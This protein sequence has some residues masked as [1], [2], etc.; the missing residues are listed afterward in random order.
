MRIFETEAIGHSVTSP[1]CLAQDLFKI[2][3]V[4]DKWVTGARGHGWHLNIILNLR[5]EVPASCLAR[6]M[7]ANSHALI[8]DRRRAAPDASRG[9]SCALALT[10]EIR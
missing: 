6:P 8:T 7:N 4:Q 1:I 5:E 2:L 10:G 3:Y 9:E